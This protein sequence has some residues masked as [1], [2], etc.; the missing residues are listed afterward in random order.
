MDTYAMGTL[1]NPIP[2][3]PNIVKIKDG[4]NRLF[5]NS[6]EGIIGIKDG[7]YTDYVSAEYLTFNKTTGVSEISLTIPDNVARSQTDVIYSYTAGGANSNI[8]YVSFISS[9]ANTGTT[10]ANSAY[11]VYV[12][13]VDNSM[14]PLLT[15]AGA[16]ASLDIGTAAN[17]TNVTASTN[18]IKNTQLD[19]D[20]FYKYPTYT[21]A[22]NASIQYF[23]MVIGGENSLVQYLTYSPSTKTFA[24]TTAYTAP[25]GEQAF[26]F[27]LYSSQTRNLF[28][29]NK[30][31]KTY[32]ATC[33]ISLNSG[34]SST[35]LRCINLETTQENWDSSTYVYSSLIEEF[36]VLSTSSITVSNPYVILKPGATP[37][38]KYFLNSTE[39]QTYNLSFAAY[40]DPAT[41]FKQL[42]PSLLRQYASQF[43]TTTANDKYLTA[44]L[45][46]TPGFSFDVLVMNKVSDDENGVLNFIYKFAYYN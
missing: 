12:V 20:Q 7:D 27:Y 8:N 44:S 46:F 45:T 15:T 16:V 35:T 41:K 22:A 9:T 3:S 14:T 26:G 2:S 4:I 36:P 33:Y 38:G 1:F 21:T 32:A 23:F 43:T 30:K 24:K 11:N 18:K 40:E 39:I 25:V 5:A 17:I 31:S 19:A 37:Q 42:Y 6:N 28:I 29:S 13:A 10:G 34:L